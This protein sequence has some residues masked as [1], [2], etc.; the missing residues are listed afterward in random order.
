M[1]S[2]RVQGIACLWCDIGNCLGDHV[3]VGL[4][5]LVCSPLGSGFFRFPIPFNT[6]SLSDQHTPTLCLSLV[7]LGPLL[8]PKQE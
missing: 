8:L 6:M 3:T 2:V 1:S 4:G 5:G 7:D